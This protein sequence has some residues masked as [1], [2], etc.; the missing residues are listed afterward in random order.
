MI[1]FNPINTDIV[2]ISCRVRLKRGSGQI[3][4]NTSGV[5]KTNSG[6]KRKKGGRKLKAMD[7]VVCGQIITAAQKAQ[8]VIVNQ[9]PRVGTPKNLVLTV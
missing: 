7:N 1:E 6:V 9:P 5:P 8:L 3:Y 2:M 4:G